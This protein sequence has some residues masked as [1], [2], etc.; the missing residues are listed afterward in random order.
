MIQLEKVETS[1]EIE[2]VARLADEIWSEHYTPIIGKEQVDYMI[3]KYQSA[4]AINQ[5]IKEGMDYT[6]FS[7]DT[8][9]C[10]YCAVNYDY[11][12]GIG[13]LSKIY[14]HKNF[15]RKGIGKKAVNC[16]IEEGRNLNLKSIRLTVNKYNEKSIRAYEKIGFKNIK[17]IVTDIGHG[18]VM[19]DYL[20]ELTL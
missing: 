14:V 8:I 5:Q 15:R 20:M 6:L 13:F 1:A 12:P 3:G 9:Y 16:I 17:S 4:K 7:S 18:F 19:D 10:G 2:E 11:E